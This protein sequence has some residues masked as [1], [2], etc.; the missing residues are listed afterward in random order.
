MQ[1]ANL[2]GF[3]QRLTGRAEALAVWDWLGGRILDRPDN[4]NNRFA[5]AAEVNRAFPGIGP[6]WGHPAAHADPDLTAMDARGGH[7]LAS[8]RRAVERLGRGAQSVLKLAGAGSVGGQSL[9]GLAA[10]TGL[11]QRHGLRVWP[12]ETGF[13]LPGPG[14]LLV[15]VYPSLYP[16]PGL[17]IPDAEQVAATAP[18]AVLRRAPE[19]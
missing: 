7:G 18:A 8:D 19:A 15:E 10:L 13:A 14:N 2:T 3:A 6:L 11:R 5:V 12:Q 16:V 1:W 4:A 17:A 9:V